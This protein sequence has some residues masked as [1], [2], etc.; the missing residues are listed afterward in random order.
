VKWQL[1]VVVLLLGFFP[2]ASADTTEAI[3]VDAIC[4]RLVSLEDAPEK[5]APDALR[6]EV[7]PLAHARVRLFSPT[8]SADCCELITPVAEVTT[9]RDGAFQFKKPTPGDYWLVAT[10]GHAEY[11]LLVRYQPG[12]KASAEC[13]KSLYAIEKGK[14][15]LRRAE[16]VTAN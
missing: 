9:A 14:L 8:A 3:S 7:K 2:A 4:G 1:L 16:T 6:Q 10:I 15:Q 11:K 5:G 12:K 13:P